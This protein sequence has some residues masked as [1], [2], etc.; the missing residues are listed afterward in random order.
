MYSRLSYLLYVCQSH[1]PPVYLIS[2]PDST[3]ATQLVDMNI[4]R[5]SAGPKKFMPEYPQAIHWTQAIHIRISSGYLPDPR[6]SYQ[7]ILR[8][9]AR[10]KKFMPEYP[11]A[12]HQTQAI[13]TRLSSGYLIWP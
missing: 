6:N 10:P 9:S 11:Q 8:L 2:P 1:A 12:I 3:V 7:N 5:L 13:H 4:L